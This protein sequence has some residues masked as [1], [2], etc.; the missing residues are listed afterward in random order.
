MAK[1]V[2]L[3]VDDDVEVLRAVARDLRSRYAE[4]YRILRA[5]SGEEALEA[6]RELRLADEPVALLLVD[7]RMPGMTG[8]EFL[9]KALEHY[10]KARRALLTAYADTEAAIQ[11]INE[12]HID[13]YLMKPWDPPE[14][15]LYPVLD[16]MLDDWSASYKPAFQGIRLIGHRWSPEAHRARDFLARNQVPYQWYELDSDPE[17]EELLRAANAT[18]A[19]LPLLLLT[20]GSVLEAPS[21]E[22]I[23]ERLGMHRPPE[24]PLYDVVVVGAGP[25]GLAAAVYGA[26]EGLRT[27]LVEADAAGGQAG[28]SSLIENYL[29]FP[30]GL[31]GADLARRALTQARRFGA[32]FLLTSEITSLETREGS[33]TLHLS[34]GSSISALSVVIATGV[35]YRRLDVPGCSELTG[36]GVYYGAASSEAESLAGEDV[37]IVGGANSAGQAAV[38][39][40]KSARKVTMLVRGK[41][42]SASMSQYL[43]KR[44]AE[45]ENIEVLYDTQVE[46]AVGQDRLEALVLCNAGGESW[47]A[48]ATTLFVFV[49]ATPRTE[50]LN[51]AVLRDQ[52]GF[53]LTGPDLL[54]EKS[55][56]ATKATERMPLLLETSAPGVFAAGDVRHGSAKRVAAA[57]GEGS[58]AVML[59]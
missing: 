6:L 34:D 30:S 57:V 44:I 58:M 18:T 26:S 2:I 14:L 27:A 33:T 19:S 21:N 54:S 39:F 41:S 59:V 42:L 9:E 48:P 50:W 1:A 49:G 17:A 16:D 13:Y 23:A 46:R 36:R 29:G 53:V 45:I 3:A 55:Y 35:T 22:T 51:D 20:D 47:T 4:Q 11:A 56:V 5:G 40:A 10:P 31:S 7:Q 43:I 38:H 15:N 32:E 37:F 25:A 28:S 8:V 12:V 52:H 24:L